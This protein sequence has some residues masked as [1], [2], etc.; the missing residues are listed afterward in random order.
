MIA[1]PTDPRYPEPKVNCGKYW[2]T[3]PPDSYVCGIVLVPTLTSKVLIEVIPV[4]GY[5]NPWVPSGN[6][7]VVTPACG[8]AQENSK[9]FKYTN[10]PDPQSLCGVS[11]VISRIPVDS[12]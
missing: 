8:A 7:V 11:V 6:I 5:S 4:T 10:S 9:S 12:T 1:T 3:V 2:R